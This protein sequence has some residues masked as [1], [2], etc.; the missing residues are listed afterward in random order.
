MEAWIQQVLGSGNAG[1]TV[2]SAVFVMGI[3]SVLT[4]GCNYAAFAVVAGYS[5]TLT[6]AGKTKNIIWSAL[7]FMLGAVIAMAAI[8]GILGYAGGL[9]SKSFGS[10]WKIIAGLVCVLFGLY[11][12]DLLPFRIPSLSVKT[13]D[14]KTGV[15]SAIL[16]G[17]TVG[18]AFSAM[19]TCCNPLFPVILAASFIKGSTAWGLTMLTIFALGFSFPLVVTMIGIRLG[20]D[21]MS[22]TVSKV[23]GV[24]KYAGGVLLIATGFYFLFT[25]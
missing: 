17:L 5:G 3:L 15:F 10:Y 9:I 4:C 13:G 23:G 14:R 20:L 12:M 6:E 24:I 11:A 19:N 8:G 1:I 16:F 21:K 22:K 7:T 18:G 2:L 25:I